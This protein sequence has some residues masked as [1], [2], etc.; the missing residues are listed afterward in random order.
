MFA[1]IGGRPHP[2]VGGLE[3]NHCYRSL[4]FVASILFGPLNDVQAATI[5]I[6]PDGTGDQPTIQAGVI[7]AAPGDTILLAA[8]TFVRTSSSGKT[9]S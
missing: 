8:G 5:Y 9:S 6:K 1:N 2:F 4:T 3:M 7:V